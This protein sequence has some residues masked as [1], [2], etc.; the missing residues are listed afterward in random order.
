MDNR[1]PG[2]APISF[3][4]GQEGDAGWF[5]ATGEGA[6]TASSLHLLSS[7]ILS[8]KTE[9]VSFSAALSKRDL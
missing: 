7:L 2:V 5:P 9:L 1:K 6:H 8:I 4:A 3:P